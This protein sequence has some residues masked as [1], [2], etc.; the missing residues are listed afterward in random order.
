MS[1][2]T[3]FAAAAASLL[4]LLLLLLLQQLLMM[5]LLLQLSVG[6]MHHCGRRQRPYKSAIE[7]KPAVCGFYSCSHPQI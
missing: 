4:L 5:M 2:P 1:S 6:S 3:R 7:Q